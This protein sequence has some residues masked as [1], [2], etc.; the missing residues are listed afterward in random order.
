M[1][2]LVIDF[3]EVICDNQFL[4][5][6]NEFFNCNKKH[7]DFEGYYIDGAIKDDETRR[8]FGEYVV[9]RNFY[10]GATIKQGAKEALEV[11]A[12]KYNIYICTAYIMPYVRELCG[13]I[14]KQ[15]Y[16]FIAE[17]FPTFDMSKIIFTNSKS[18]TKADIMIDDNV[19]NL[20]TN[21]SYTK[22][23]YTAD[24]NA[25][26]PE[27]ELR[28]RNLVRVNNWQEVVDYLMKEDV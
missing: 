17:Q 15:K 27:D 10:K 28:A 3:D 14:L 12:T 2:T 6:Y 23:L 1:K 24:H 13:N 5:A 26:M 16:E 4:Q 19:N 22:L 8:A 21:V 7:S 11:L 9:K 20:L 25:S 18:T